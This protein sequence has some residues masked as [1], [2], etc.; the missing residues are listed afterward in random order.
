MEVRAH[1]EIQKRTNPSQWRGWSSFGF[2]G[3]SAGVGFQE[4]LRPWKGSGSTSAYEE[5]E[6]AKA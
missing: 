3:S 5:E 2:C 1:Y 6:E 4:I